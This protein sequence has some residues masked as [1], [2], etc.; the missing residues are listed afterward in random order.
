MLKAKDIMTKNVISLEKKT[1]I[2]QAL[3]VLLDNNISSI[4]VVEE[5]NT[6]VGILSE[7]DV[8][9]LFGKEE[10][11]KSKKVNDYM[12]QPAV[13]FDENENLPDICDCLMNN[14]FKA[15]PVTSKGKL[16][17]IVSRRDILKYIIEQNET[18]G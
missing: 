17:G 3:K 9:K 16:T 10:K 6:L 11:S 4:P 8:L 2:S 13:H 1:P 15:V 14:Y 12:T 18:A 5:D 7:K